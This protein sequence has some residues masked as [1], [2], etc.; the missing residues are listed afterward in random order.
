MFIVLLFLSGI[1][2]DDHVFNWL[3]DWRMLTQDSIVDVDILA[4]IPEIKT[5]LGNY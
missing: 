2:F 1:P 4:V 3:R 5:R